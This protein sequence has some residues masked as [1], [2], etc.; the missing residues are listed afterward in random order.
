MSIFS[1]LQREQRQAIGLLSIGTFLEYFDLFLYIHM[2]V[3]LNDLFFPKTDTHSQALLSAFA[4][5]S[6]FVFRPIGALL[7]GYIGDT[8]GRKTTIVLTTFI[9]ATTCVIMANAPTYA[10]VGITAAWLVTL[11]RALQGMSSMGEIVGAQLFLTE[12]V[13][14]SARYPAVGV[15][16]IFADLGSFFAL[17][18]ATLATAY[19]FNWRLAFWVG[20]GVAIVGSA[21]RTTLRETPEFA[22][23]KRRIKNIAERV[24]EDPSFLE[25]SPF[26]NQKVNKKTALAYFLIKC[27]SPVFLYF[28][29]FYTGEILKNEFSYAIHQVI[30][31]NLFVLCIQILG[32]SVLR[33]YLSTRIYPLKIL[34]TAWMITFVFIPFLPWLLGHITAIWQLFLIQAFLIVFWANDLPAVPIF[35]KN[36]PVFK[37]FSYASFLY[38]LAYALLY[39]ITSFGLTYLIDYFGYWGLLV[40]MVPALIGY[41]YGL[42]HFKQLEI[43]AGRYPL[44]ERDMKYKTGK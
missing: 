9:M 3:L 42:N 24:N 41:G 44:K 20:A 6:A 4:F 37:R 27:T 12:A 25:K 18:I 28:I 7:F 16:S 35:F 34:Q 40:I 1:S 5:S 21:A 2:A 32:W 10:Q 38:A 23:A 14:L 8:Y 30:M 13:P 43:A 17:G 39:L 29:Y 15:I 19:G 36:F 31:H 11:C 26:Y 22:D 33:T